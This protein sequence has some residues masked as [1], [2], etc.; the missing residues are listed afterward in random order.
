MI[1][2]FKKINKDA[3]IERLKQF[4]NDC[5]INVVSPTHKEI[6]NLVSQFNLDQSNLLSGTDPHE[7]PRADFIGDDAYIYVKVPYK[8]SG[9]GTF[10]L[11]LVITK[12]FV[13]TLS[14]EEPEFYQSIMANNIK[15]ISTSQKSKFIIH[16]LSLNNAMFEAKTLEIVRSIETKDI[17]KLKD[18]DINEMIKHEYI[19]NSFVSFYSY[20]NF[21]YN[22]IIHRLGLLKQDKDV[23]EE[24]MIDTEEGRNICDASLKNISNIR[25]YN[26]ILLTS[27]LNRIITV[28]TI[29]TVFL[30]VVAAITGIYGMNIEI[31]LQGNRNAFLFVASLIILCWTIFI[32]YLKKKKI[33]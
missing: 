26:M 23:L 11:L 24:L 4:E 31:P 30:S 27:N 14:K 28:L 3:N 22:K 2:F 32:W 19:L 18:K 33:I 13:L 9:M 10:T 5:W 1:S 21:M 15:D 8:N 12:T 25:N 6:D 17:T 16:F 7:I 29:I 20:T